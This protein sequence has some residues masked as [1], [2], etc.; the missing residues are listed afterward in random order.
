MSE[1]KDKLVG[2]EEYKDRQNKMR[3]IAAE[4]NVGIDEH[5]EHFVIPVRDEAGNETG[6]IMLAARETIPIV[7]ENGRPMENVKIKIAIEVS[8][9][10]PNLSLRDA[11]RKAGKL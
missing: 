6:Q 11:L 7:D 2:Y 4:M 3:T 5:A 9:Q 1:Q 10:Y 8:K